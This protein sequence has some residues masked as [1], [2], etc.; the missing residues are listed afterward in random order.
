MYLKVKCKAIKVLKDNRGENLDDFGFS[1]DFLNKTLKRGSIKKK[2][3][4]KISVILVFCSI[5]DNI[6]RT[7][8]M[9]QSR[10]NICK[11]YI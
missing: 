4:N 10:K 7:K 2:T 3:F 9:P 5:K 11:T 6:K 1:D 8:F